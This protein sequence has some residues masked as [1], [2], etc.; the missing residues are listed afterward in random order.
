MLL[1]LIKRGLR[2]INGNWDL[3]NFSLEKWESQTKKTIEL[4]LSFEK[5]GKQSAGKWNFCKIWVEEWDFIPHPP[6]PPVTG[7]PINNDKVLLIIMSADRF[8][9]EK[10]PA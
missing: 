10:R 5:S 1:T 4:G 9:L 6:P 8:P 3:A 7:T 2:G